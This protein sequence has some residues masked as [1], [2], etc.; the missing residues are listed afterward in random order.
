MVQIQR[1]RLPNR[2]SILPIRLHLI[3]TAMR[4]RRLENCVVIQLSQYRDEVIVPEE[5]AAYEEGAGFAV[6]DHV[7]GV[8]VVRITWLVMRIG[9]LQ[10][11]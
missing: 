8:G 2:L 5:L 4:V 10:V 11:H 7:A 9:H 3:I 1:S 6:A